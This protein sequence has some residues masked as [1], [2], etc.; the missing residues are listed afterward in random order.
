[1]I[2]DWWQKT[3]DGK[4]KKKLKTYQ[5][6]LWFLR[7]ITKF[8]N[9]MLKKTSRKVQNSTFCF[10]NISV[11]MRSLCKYYET[12]SWNISRFNHVFRCFFEFPAAS[13]MFLT[14]D[15]HQ[16]LKFLHWPTSSISGFQFHVTSFHQS[17]IPWKKK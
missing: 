6:F 9:K 3:R 15:M 8:M 17:H 11:H 12:A 1:M 13:P 5:I 4:T 10:D 16:K 7:W 14:T 2:F